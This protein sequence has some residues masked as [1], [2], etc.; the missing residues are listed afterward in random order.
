MNFHTWFIKDNDLFVLSADYELSLC[1]VIF[2]CFVNLGHARDEVQ[3]AKSR[4]IHNILW[5]QETHLF[6]DELILLLLVFKGKETGW[7]VAQAVRTVRL[8][9]SKQFLQAIA[10]ILDFIFLAG[11]GWIFI[12]VDL[13]A[14]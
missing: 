9:V 10:H 6:T 7:H 11:L 12:L 5:F 1:F 3:M 13:S 4:P 8:S 14:G 2:D